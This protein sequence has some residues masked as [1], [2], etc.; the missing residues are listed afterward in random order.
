MYE[1]CDSRTLRIDLLRFFR[2][3]LG[4]KRARCAGLFEARY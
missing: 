1:L 4:L 2:F 3:H